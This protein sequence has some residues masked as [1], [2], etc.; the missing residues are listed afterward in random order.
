VPQDQATL[1]AKFLQK[2]SDRGAGVSTQQ[3][4]VVVSVDTN[5]QT[6]QGRKRQSFTVFIP[7]NTSLYPAFDNHANGSRI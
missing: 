2:S 6:V 7:M 4:G 3:M 5:S 1:M